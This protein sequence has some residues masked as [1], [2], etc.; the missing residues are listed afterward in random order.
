MELFYRQ[1]GEGRPVIILHGLFGMCDNW[2]TF[3][4]KLAEINFSVFTPDFRNH[5]NSPH[6]G[7]FSYEVLSDDLNEFIR[8]HNIMNPVLIGHS[9]GGKVVMNFTLKFPRVAGKIIIIDTGIRKYGIQN[10]D[11]LQAIVNCGISTKKTRQE[12]EE[13]LAGKI[14]QKKVVQLLMKNVQRNSNNTFNWK[15]NL[16]AIRKNFDE[17]FKAV[18]HIGKSNVPALFI[19]AENSDYISGND[20]PAIREIFPLSNYICIPGT[21]H[22]VHADK[23]AEL[24][25]AVTGFIDKY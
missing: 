8:Q 14:K 6:S 21:T 13:A 25:R 17:I 15:L 23:P 11:V 9:L 12:I 10:E 1:Y 22:W 20:M 3:S 5:G 2:V 18:E 19:A 7:V 4:K 24:L 16:E